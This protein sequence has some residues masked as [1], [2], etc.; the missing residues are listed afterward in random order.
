MENSSR[1]PLLLDHHGPDEYN[2]TE[3]YSSGKHNIVTTVDEV[4]YHSDDEEVVILDLVFMDS[5][6]NTSVDM[7][8]SDAVLFHIRRGTPPYTERLRGAFDLVTYFDITTHGQG[9]RV[10][11][12]RGR[13]FHF[14]RPNGG[15]G[16]ANFWFPATS[17][18]QRAQGGAQTFTVTELVHRTSPGRWKNITKLRD[19]VVVYGKRVALKERPGPTTED[20]N[21]DNTILQAKSVLLATVLNLRLDIALLTDFLAVKDRASSQTHSAISHRFLINTPLRFH[22]CSYLPPLVRLSF[23]MGSLLNLPTEILLFTIGFFESAPLW[24]WTPPHRFPAAQAAPPPAATTTFSILSESF[25][26]RH[27]KPLVAVAVT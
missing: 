27:D 7:W 19:K 21:F 22:T 13:I 5:T 1:S 26:L 4:F 25:L 12:L 15:L 6:R 8:S 24:L 17:R 18:M 14:L 23:T 10:N 2:A 11:K 9:V 20:F 3:L 16:L